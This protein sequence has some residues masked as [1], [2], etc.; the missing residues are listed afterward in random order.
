MLT[1]SSSPPSTRHTR[2]GGTSHLRSS[3][4][5]CQRCVRRLWRRRPRGCQVRAR[6]HSTPHRWP[7]TEQRTS[8]RRSTTIEVGR[9]VA[10]Q[11]SATVRGIET[12][13]VATSRETSTCMHQRV[14]AKLRMHLSLAPREFGGG[15]CMALA[16]HLRMVVWPPMFQ[17]PPAREVQRDGQPHQVPADLLHLHPRDRRE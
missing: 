17:P 15:G 11:S 12:S 14:R 10:P 8:G 13:R 3:H 7:A 2:K 4:A 9:I 5:F 6:R 1:S 16:L